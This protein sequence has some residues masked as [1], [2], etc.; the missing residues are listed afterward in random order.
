[1]K[2]QQIS[3]IYGVILFKIR[4]IARTRCLGVGYSG[5]RPAS[6][7]ARHGPGRTGGADGGRVL[8]PEIHH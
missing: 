6:A 2:A 7:V 3:K 4:S 8:L 5:T 1:M